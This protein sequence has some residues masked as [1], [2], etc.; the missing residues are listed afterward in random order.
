ML[1]HDLLVGYSVVACAATL[2]LGP[3]MRFGTLVLSLGSGVRLSGVDRRRRLVAVSLVCALVR[4]DQ[5]WMIA[6]EAGV[7]VPAPAFGSTC[8][9]GPIRERLGAMCCRPSLQILLEPLEEEFLLAEKSSGSHV[10]SSFALTVGFPGAFSPLPAL[11]SPPQS[12]PAARLSWTRPGPA[13]IV[14]EQAVAPTAESASVV[15][16]EER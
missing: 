10:P 12:W 15:G 1:A 2:V 11:F 9:V 5:M 4:Q 3:S 6:V 7:V 13:A 8:T 16:A 14:E